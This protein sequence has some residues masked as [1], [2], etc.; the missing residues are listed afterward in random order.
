MK[1][2]LFT[3]I[4][5]LVLFS[6]TIFSTTTFAYT[7]YENQHR[8]H[9]NKESWYFYPFVYGNNGKVNLAYSYTQSGSYY[10]GYRISLAAD[11]MSGRINYGTYY[12][13]YNSYAP[14][15]M[16]E[17]T[18]GANITITS[19]NYGNVNWVGNCSYQQKVKPIK[20]NEYWIT[21]SGYDYGIEEYTVVTVHEMLHAAGLDH[22]NCTDEV[23]YPSERG[24]N[25]DLHPGD[26]GGVYDIY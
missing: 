25:F 3:K 26:I 22:Y 19:N 24:A 20:L 8:S 11:T 13:G 15:N 16:Y 5:F 7:D 17:N 4:L 1:K 10:F 9:Y 21:A 18:S 6:L 14:F 12:M 2:R 23:M